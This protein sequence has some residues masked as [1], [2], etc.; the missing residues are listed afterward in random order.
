MIKQWQMSLLR[1][2]CE[3]FLFE[4]RGYPLIVELNRKVKLDCFRQIKLR[5]KKNKAYQVYQQIIPDLQTSKAF[6]PI[7]FAPLSNTTY[8]IF[9][10]NNFK[11]AY[12]PAIENLYDCIVDNA[13][14]NELLTALKLTY[15]STMLS[16]GLQNQ[17]EIV[18]YNIPYCFAVKTTCIPNYSEFYHSINA[19]DSLNG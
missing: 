14:D 9:P 11:F 7:R 6:W 10:I 3:Q 1:Y 15:N 4:S 16:T 17:R 18:L 13:D 12:N 19:E 8:Y 5:W 2:Q